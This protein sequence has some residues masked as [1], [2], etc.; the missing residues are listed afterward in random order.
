[1]MI[2][3]KQQFMGM[4][5]LKITFKLKACLRLACRIWMLKKNTMMN[6]DACRKS[7]K[8]VD[9]NTY[10]N[11]RQADFQTLLIPDN[12]SKKRGMPMR[13]KR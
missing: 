9:A 2:M 7:T 6:T 11:A 13:R 8:F 1:M 12:K 3:K 5:R 4:M 10:I